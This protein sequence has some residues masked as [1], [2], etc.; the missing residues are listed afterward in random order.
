MVAGG[1][2]VSHSVVVAGSSHSVHSGLV[3]EGVAVHSSLSQS[4]TVAVLVTPPEDAAPVVEAGADPD[5]DPDPEVASAEDDAAEE[6][7]VA[8]DSAAEVLLAPGPEVDAAELAAE[9][10]SELAAAWASSKPVL[11]PA[12]RPGKSS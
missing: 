5:P 4:V 10:A 6:E 12:L 1:A 3:E 11:G 7:S 9:L 2:W 8:D